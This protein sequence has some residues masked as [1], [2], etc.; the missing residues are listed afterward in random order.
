MIN[1]TKPPP[2]GSGQVAKSRLQTIIFQDRLERSP[3]VLELLKSDMMAVMAA[4][5]D[6][7]ENDME[8][9]LWLPNSKGGEGP[10]LTAT[11][12]VKGWKARSD[13]T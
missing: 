8:I 4:Y 5:L 7:D 12:P 1:T 2:E 6:F 10:T 3:K 9:D 13:T 11:V